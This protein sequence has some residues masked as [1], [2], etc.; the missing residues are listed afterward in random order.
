[1]LDYRRWVV[2]LCAYVKWKVVWLSIWAKLSG[3]EIQCHVEVVDNLK[4]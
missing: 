3:R 1:M 2:G 4:A